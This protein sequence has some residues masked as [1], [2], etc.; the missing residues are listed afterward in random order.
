M[1]KQL[2]IVTPC[3]NEETNIKPFFDEVI[4]AL[5]LFLPL[6]SCELIYVNDGSTD[7]SIQYFNEVCAQNSLDVK[8]IHLSRN[9]GKEAAMLTGL[10]HAAGDYVVLMDGD[11]QHPPQLLEQLYQAACNHPVD[12]VIAKRNRTGES[13]MRSWLTRTYY[14]KINRL[15]NVN[16]EDGVGD[17]R[18]LSRRAVDA[19]L[20]CS[21][22]NR[23]SKGLFSWIGFNTH[24]LSYDN[25]ARIHGKSKWS[26]ASLLNYAIDGVL[27]FN[28]QPLR[29]AMHAGLTIFI[30]ACIYLIIEIALWITGHVSV[31]GYVTIIAII[32]AFAGVQLF[33]LGVIG[34]YVG[35][36]YMEVK[37]RPH[38]II[39][40]IQTN[41]RESHDG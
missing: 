32:I 20:A 10:Q 9:F 5:S 8:V 39:T 11:L 29:V 23:F 41:K 30:I 24:T 21:E 31:S 40:S 25:V 37:Q 6:D 17:F 14:S 15:M 3:H 13:C 38:A 16:L 34:E 4:G 28:H 36:I 2:S 1:H 35:R 7:R 26:L 27:S 19:L 18:L 12:Q 22:R 33:A